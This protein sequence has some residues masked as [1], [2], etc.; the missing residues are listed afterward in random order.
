MTLMETIRSDLKA[1]MKS[2]DPLRLRT[3]RSVIAAVQEAETAGTKSEVDDGG[4]QKIIA[5]QVKRRVEAAEAFDAGNRPGKAADERAEIEVLEAYLPQ[6]LSDGELQ[7]LVE[8]VLAAE[9]LTQKSQM[10]AAMKAVNAQ[11]A[12]R[13][14]GRVVADA[15]KA[16]LS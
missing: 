14:D 1:A 7:A 13:A 15:V 3:L 16:R 8:K 6:M 5:R 10:G 2:R 12:G 11:V 9:G 4:I